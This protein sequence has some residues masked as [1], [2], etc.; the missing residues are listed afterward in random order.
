MFRR[1]ILKIS[2]PARPQFYPQCFSHLLGDLPLD[3]EAVGPADVL[4]VAA[5]A[6]DH[7]RQL[8]QEAR[9]AQGGQLD[10]RKACP[11]CRI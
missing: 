7:L 4:V 8:Q 3:D 11:V 6:D 2:K 9:P 5:R 10:G 1:I